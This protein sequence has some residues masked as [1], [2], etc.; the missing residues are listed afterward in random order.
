MLTNKAGLNDRAAEMIKRMSDNGVLFTYAT[1]RRFQSAGFIMHKA[2][3]S[4]PVITM[5]GVIIS[6]GKNGYVISINCFTESHTQEA[7]KLI[8]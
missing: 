3:I 4:L 8:K 7:I 5:N 1:A 2:E 6:E